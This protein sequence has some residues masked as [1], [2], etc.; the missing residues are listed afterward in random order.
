MVGW[1]TKASSNPPHFQGGFVNKN[2]YLKIG[3]EFR[4]FLQ[5]ATLARGPQFEFYCLVNP[6]RILASKFV[7][8]L[9]T[10]PALH[11]KNITT[12]ESD[13]HIFCNAG[14][15]FYEC[16]ALGAPL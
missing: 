1:A 4:F 7:M 15:N 3:A 5:T 14:L 10:F 13:D 12:M 6:L 11:Y 9:F 2:K 8:K 16:R